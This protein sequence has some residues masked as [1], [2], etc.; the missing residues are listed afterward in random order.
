LSLEDNNK[1]VFSVIK[2]LTETHK[3]NTEKK[4]HSLYKLHKKY[5]NQWF[6]KDRFWDLSWQIDDNFN[7]FDERNEE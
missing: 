3:T 7:P 6:I 5:V 2:K 1:E 4:L